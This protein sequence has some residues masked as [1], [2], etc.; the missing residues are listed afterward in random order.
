[1]GA[2][3]FALVRT[4]TARWGQWFAPAD[5]GTLITWTPV[6]A[7]VAGRRLSGVTYNVYRSA[8]PDGCPRTRL[9]AAPLDTPG[10]VDTDANPSRIEYYLICAVF[11]GI[12]GTPSVA[13][14]VGE[15]D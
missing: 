10:Y 15:A 13:A 12:E 2:A 1:M 4:A 7:S 14:R 8:S 3:A 11:A 6:V 5:A 9:N